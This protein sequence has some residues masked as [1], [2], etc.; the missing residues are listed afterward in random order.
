MLFEPQL[1]GQEFPVG[2]IGH[3]GQRATAEGQNVGA[4]VAVVEA[5]NVALQHLEIGQ[6]MVGEQHRLGSLQMGVSGHHRTHV[7]LGQV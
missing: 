5:L 3:P 4:T 6:Q 1:S 7:Y 2:G